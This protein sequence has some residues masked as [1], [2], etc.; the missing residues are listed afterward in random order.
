MIIEKI[1]ISSN[2]DPDAIA[3]KYSS[4]I[5]SVANIKAGREVVKLCR[6]CI[7]KGIDF[8]YE[9]T[10]SGKTAVA[11]LEAAK[12]MGYEITMFYVGL[13]NVAL[14]IERVESRV[15]SGGHFIDK[16]DILARSKTSVQNL[17]D[18]SD[19]IDNLI[20]INNTGTVG[21]IV[22][23]VNGGVVNYAEPFLPDWAKPVYEKYK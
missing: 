9:T 15:K 21:K 6:E 10:F 7:Q 22:L 23:E 11:R 12:S 16:K 5:K 3:R 8:S 17:Y 14:N 1:G 18:H 4:E 13:N 20:L 2:I 19:L